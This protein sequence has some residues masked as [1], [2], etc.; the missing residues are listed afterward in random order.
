[1]STLKKVLLG[2]V[3]LAVIA[4]GVM[5]VT[6][7]KKVEAAECSITQTLK[8]GSK[9]VEVSCLQAYLGGLVADGSFGPKT[10]ASVVVWQA[11]KG[12][13]PDGVFG[14]LSR[15]AWSASLTGSGNLPAGCS[16]INGYSPLTGVKC[17]GS[18]S[19]T[20]TDV[21]SGGAGSV[22][23]TDSSEFKT[24]EVEEGDKSVEVLAFS[25]EADD[26]SDVAVTSVKVTLENLD[27]ASSP[28]LDDYAD[29]VT[30][31]YKGVKVGSADVS[32]FSEDG[33]VWS[34]SISLSGVVIKAGDKEDLVVAIT[35]I[36]NI[37]SSD[38]STDD[39][40]VNVSSLRFEDGDG[41]ISTESGLS[42]EQ[43]FDFVVAGDGEA[44]TIKSS[45]DDL[46]ASTLLVDDDNESDWHDVF[47]FKLE[48]DESDISLD[49]LVLK[50]STGTASFDN[51]VSDVKVTIDGDEFSDF[52]VTGGAS[53]TATLDFDLD[54]DFTIDADET[55]VVVVSVKLRSV[56][57]HYLV[58]E[59]VK[60]EATSV[61]GEGA[62]DLSDTSSITSAEHI[63]A[64]SV[65]VVSNTS[66]TTSGTDTTGV[67]D[68]FFTV[69]A[70][71][72][73]FDVLTADIIDGASVGTLTRVSGDSVTVI[74]GGF[75][76][77]EGDTTRFRV[78]YTFGPLAPGS[79][80]VTV[81]SVAGQ[82]VDED[83]QL[84]PT[85]ILQ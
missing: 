3:V 66:W 65:A 48:S 74:G 51:V 2:L 11:A 20:S 1:M 45:S 10:K 39:W 81:T 8:L 58:G 43:S 59:T 85:L 67:L 34:K 27:L 29:S 24:E 12:L 78:R 84:S 79:H 21:L 46:D 5:A 49:T 82:E 42:V 55:V 6:P 68:F 18:V 69:T 26:E 56:T 9:N 23:V 31:L 71:E 70:G 35:A 62:D 47:E 77:A 83:D 37:D 50:V 22:T 4:L 63:L 16:S 54:G 73:D 57:G 53:T 75:Q 33:D 36:S 25:V 14:P 76:V 72:D 44:L 32:D 41:V 61:E 17:G 15:A 28:D 13:T 60:V 40:E 64:T 38:T 80:E 52:D 30:V 7:A 19:S